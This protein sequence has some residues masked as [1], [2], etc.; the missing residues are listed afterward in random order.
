MSEKY[1]IVIVG[2]GPGGLSAAGR[3]AQL[4][5]SHALLEAS[6]YLA[7]T[8]HH[9][10]KGKSVMAEPALLP[11]RSSMSFAAGVREEILATWQQ[12]IEQYRVN[13][14]LASPVTDISGCAGD[15]CITLATGETLHAD[16]VVLAIG[17]QGNIRKLAV[18]GEDLPGVQYQ[19][20]DPDEFSN[21]TIVVVGGGDAGVENAL[22]LARQ[23]RVIL[24]N[25]HEEFSDC[26]AL[27]NERLMAAIAQ[28]K[29]ETRI[30]SHTECIEALAGDTFPLVYVVQ[31]PLGQERIAC[32]RVIARLGAKPPRPLLEHFGVVFPNADSTAVPQLSEQYE[33][34]VPG[35][36]IVGA[37]A[38]YPLIKQAMNQGYEVIE[39][40]LGNPVEP[41]DE[42]LL[43]AK[44]VDVPDVF[45]VSDGIAL[46]R[47][48]LPLLLSLTTLQLREFMLD[49]TVQILQRGAVVFNSN[50]YSNSFYSIL[51][52]C[53]AIETENGQGEVNV[54]GLHEGEFF[55]EMGLLSGRRRS[56]T[57]VVS[58]D[59]VLVE[60]PRRSMLKLLYSSRGVQRRLDEV[61]LKR[62]VRTCLDT[63][64]PESEL[65]Y[66]V[67]GAQAKLYAAGDALFCEGDA[68]D[69]LYLIRRGSVT[70]SRQREG[71]DVVLAYLPA[72]NYVGEMALVSGQP[73]SAT[74]RAASPAE[75]ILLE[76]SRVGEVLGRNT[77][78]RSKVGSQYLE[79]VRDEHTRDE[80]YGH[81]DG[82]LVNFLMEQGV[83]EASDVLLIDYARCIRCNNCE[84]SCADAHDGTSRLDREAGATYAQIHVPTSCRHCEHPHCMKDCPPDAIHRSVN[85]EVYIGDNCIGCGNCQ[86]NCPYGVIQMAV[87]QTYHMRSLWQVIFGVGTRQAQQGA[88][89]PKKAVKCDMCKDILGGPVCVR[90]CPTGA[91]M[92]GHPEELLNYAE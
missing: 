25:R 5:I 40:I 61:S 26:K 68:A 88:D 15:F 27:N 87:E 35:L 60:T 84:T 17:L 39:Y 78:F 80:A 7:N 32:H 1:K 13:L 28:G 12:E 44:F 2:A 83:G 63:A 9:F 73:R 90:A 71:R 70:V 54:F 85:G 66:L 23:N 3:A 33:S 24:V 29:I 62:V 55:G 59:C 38:G 51:K 91:A 42:A 20:D 46:L 82:G 18:S 86:T 52:G 48:N 49:S 76:A 37:L 57:A 81:G 6:P 69:G 4:G 11:L 19:L 53:V 75:V 10:Q 74:V 65:D 8:I 21:E 89:L 14:R 43:R 77:L 30:S 41:A 79:N 16:Y 22:G 45:S 36:Y 64:L 34:N 72:G 56:G 92:R 31:T 58:Q 50:D 67:Q 47:R